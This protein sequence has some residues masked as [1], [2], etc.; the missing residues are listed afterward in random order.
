MVHQ[1]KTYCRANRLSIRGQIHPTH[2]RKKK[3]VYTFM[4][5]SL[6]YFELGHTLLWIG[7]H[8]IHLYA[9]IVALLVSIWTSVWAPHS[10]DLKL[11]FSMKLFA[12]LELCGFIK[13][14]DSQRGCTEPICIQSNTFARPLQPH[15]AKP[16]EALEMGVSFYLLAASSLQNSA[17]W[18]VIPCGFQF[19]FTGSDSPR[20]S[21]DLPQA[22]S[23][24]ITITP[25][26]P[27]EN[28]SSW[29]WP[30]QHADLNARKLK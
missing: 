6:H 2:W 22:W 3:T 14:Y 29:P 24:T 5:P 12:V 16:V 17:F 26:V 23:L 25:E 8:S 9:T 10:N 4:Q 7:T 28:V 18:V 27:S 19:S 15:Y 13:I 1:A 11:A 20:G 30:P 21:V